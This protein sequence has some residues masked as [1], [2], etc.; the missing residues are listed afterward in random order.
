MRWLSSMICFMFFVLHISVKPDQLADNQPKN[1]LHYEERT[2][3]G[4]YDIML[5]FFLVR[6]LKK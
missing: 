2:N 3:F 5:T 1:I 6:N 4:A